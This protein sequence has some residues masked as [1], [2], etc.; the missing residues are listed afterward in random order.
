MRVREN[1]S[2]SSDTAVIWGWSLCTYQILK[3][4][5]PPLY[6]GFQQLPSG[7]IS[8]LYLPCWA[9]FLLIGP[10]RSPSHPHLAAPFQ[11]PTLFC[12]LTLSCSPP[13]QV[14]FKIT[15]YAL[16]SESI[17]AQSTLKV[18]TIPD[19]AT[20]SLCCTLMLQAYP[21]PGLCLVMPQ[22]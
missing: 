9:S 19:A 11:W 6:G 16:S 7:Q 13:C 18:L 5:K 10:L 3:L 21:H 17:L 14:S 1:G 20:S 15:Q 8:Y 4:L 12:P 2:N 22:K